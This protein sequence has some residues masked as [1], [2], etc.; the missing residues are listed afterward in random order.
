MHRLIQSNGIVCFTIP[1]EGNGSA[2]APNPIPTIF[3]PFPFSVQNLQSPPEI[4]ICGSRLLLIAAQWMPVQVEQAGGEGEPVQ[5]EQATGESEV[6]LEEENEEEME[7]EGEN[8]EDLG[9]EIEEEEDDLGGESEEEWGE[10]EEDL[11]A[12]SEEE[13]GEEEEDDRRDLEGESEEDLGAGEREEE[14]R[15]CATSATSRGGE[16]GGHYYLG[17]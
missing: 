2:V 6:E 7:L 3:A 13:G 9:A 4:K 12:E 14:R 8:E 10:N 5:V 1:L 16:G 11:G 15:P 17:I